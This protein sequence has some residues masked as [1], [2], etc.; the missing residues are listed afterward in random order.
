MR[1][2][3][4]ETSEQGAW[5]IFDES[6]YATLSMIDEEGLPYAIMISPARTKNTVYLHCAME[7]KKMDC[8]AINPQVCLSAVSY[9]EIP[10]VGFTVDFASCILQGRA[11]IVEDH[12]EKIHALRIISERY[13]LDR[14]EGFDQAIQHS[15]SITCVVKIDVESITGKKKIRKA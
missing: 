10:P 12:D 5:E 1:K 6:P 4:R 14:M 15:L 9:V 11:S 3:N 13:T 8:L 2:K 7:G